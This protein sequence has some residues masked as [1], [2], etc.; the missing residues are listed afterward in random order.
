MNKILNYGLSTIIALT[1]SGNVFSQTNKEL[2][3][4]EKRLLEFLEKHPSNID[5]TKKLADIQFKL[6]NID[7]ATYTYEKILRFDSTDTHAMFNLAKCYIYGEHEEELKK[8]ENIITKI[9]FSKRYDKELLT[10][11]YLNRA[12]VRSLLSSKPNDEYSG[13]RSYDLI[14]ASKLD[15]L[16]P[17]IFYELGIYYDDN[18]FYESALESFAKAVNLEEQIAK[19]ENRN[20]N[21]IYIREFT[22]TKNNYKLFGRVSD[23]NKFNVISKK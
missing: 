20:M 13:K 1:M 10:K 23:A 5:S 22:K 15:S 19:Q 11:L 4:D 8:A 3:K 21:T 17:N 9:I 7:D 6:D 16:N 12:E 18:G 2:K 14:M